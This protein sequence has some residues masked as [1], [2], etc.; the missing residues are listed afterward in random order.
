MTDYTYSGNVRNNRIDLNNKIANMKEGIL[1]KKED[2]LVLNEAANSIEY[3]ENQNKLLKTKLRQLTD[4]YKDLENQY[5]KI[6]EENHNIRIVKKAGEDIVR[7]EMDIAYIAG[8]FDGEGS[9]YYARRPEKK[10]KHKGKGY[11]ISNSLRMSMEI[12]MTD[13]SVIR[14]VHEVLGCGTVVRKPR[15]GLRKDGTKYLVQ[16]KWRCTFRDAYYVCML[17]APYAHT[18]LAKIRQITDHYANKDNY[19]KNT[20]VVSLKDYKKALV[21]E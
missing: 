14:W 20:K 17:L 16:W 15:K 19:L 6:W 8:L 21:F 9:I 18:K 1:F 10:K 3:L 5:N 13:Q 4:K 11:R 2:M 7:S 12:T